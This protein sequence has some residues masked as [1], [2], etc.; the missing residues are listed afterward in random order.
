MSYINKGDFLVLD[1]DRKVIALGPDYT[2]LYYDAD[3]RDMMR[4]GLDYGVA[5]G[6]VKVLEPSSSREMKV[7][8]RRIKKI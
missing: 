8:I 1:G 3:A 5:R 6:V 7:E 4:Y 2:E